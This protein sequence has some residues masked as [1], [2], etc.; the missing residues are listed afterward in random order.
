LEKLRHAGP[1][2]GASVV[3]FQCGEIPRG[4][5]EDFLAGRHRSDH[6]AREQAERAKVRREI[7]QL[8][9]GVVGSGLVGLAGLIVSLLK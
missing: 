8:W 7:I 4:V 1:G 3:G 6:D 2:R 9:V 5:V